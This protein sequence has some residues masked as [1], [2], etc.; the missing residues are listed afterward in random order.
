MYPST[1]EVLITYQTLNPI[2]R[3]A[4]N[5]NGVENN[6]TLEV[7]RGQTYQITVDAPSPHALWIKTNLGSGS[8][9]SY[10]TGVVGNGSSKI[11]WRVSESAP[12]RLAYSSF[13]SPEISGCIAVSN[14]PPAAPLGV[15]TYADLWQALDYLEESLSYSPKNIAGQGLELVGTRL[16]LIDVGRKYLQSEAG[17]NY[18]TQSV[19]LI[20]DKVSTAVVPTDLQ[21]WL[22]YLASSLRQLKGS[23]TYDTPP[24][25]SLVAISNRIDNAELELQHLLSLL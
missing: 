11:K 1:P 10:N 5:I 23:D 12:D 2:G 14:L 17:V 6:P 19:F 16:S 4:Y 13:T 22:N 21:S 3:L 24:P 9:S 7:V 25:P 18:T 8:T 15:A 20:N